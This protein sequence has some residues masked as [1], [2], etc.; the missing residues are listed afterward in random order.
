MSRLPIL[1]A[2]QI[3]AALK[4]AGFEVVEQ[5]G[6]HIHL[7]NPRRTGKVTVPNHGSRDIPRALLKKIIAQ[8][9]MTADEFLRLL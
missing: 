1:R 6:S 7:K 5:E 8:A 4:R 2:R 9:G 3:V